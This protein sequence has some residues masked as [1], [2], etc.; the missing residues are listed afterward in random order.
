MSFKKEIFWSLLY[1]LVVACPNCVLGANSCGVLNR[2]GHHWLM[3]LNVWLL[4]NGITWQEFWGV[5]Y[6]TRCD[7]VG[8][9]NVTKSGHKN[10]SASFSD[11][12]FFFLGAWLKSPDFPKYCS[13]SYKLDFFLM[14][15]FLY[16]M[17]DIDKNLW[18][19][20]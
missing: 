2:K 9:I 1:P 20:V 14:R 4:E 11:L 12:C 18:I 3:Y 19:N 10:T 17:V 7:L 13:N 8:G 16:I 5:A 15:V 6:L